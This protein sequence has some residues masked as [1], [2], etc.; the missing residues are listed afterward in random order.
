MNEQ[1]RQQKLLA[2]LDAHKALSTHDLVAML[3]VSPA[4]A[5]RDISK[6][7]AQG[8]LKKVRNGVE[9]LG[10][11]H[12][13]LH[14]GHKSPGHI[15]RY[16]EKRRIAAAAATLCKNGASVVL[17]CGSTMMLLGE[18]LCGREVQVVTNYLPLANKLI[19]GDHHDVV[20]LGGQYNK[21][22]GVTLSL[23]SESHYAADILFTSGKGFSA[24]GLFKND[25]LIAHSEQKLLDKAERL[26][27]LVDSSKLGKEVGMLFAPLADV[28][29]LITGQ[30]AD[31]AI[32]A[33]L[34]EQGLDVLLA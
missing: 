11:A 25:M 28:D 26:V 30:E 16:D 2:L 12:A 3:A 13:P 17:T 22:K 24:A 10:A 7:H 32:I 18:A 5:R 20:I 14:I 27:A 9:A 19:T 33:R 29:L 1:H 15:N 34:R 31:P 23:G 4:T 6:L 21:N 8:R